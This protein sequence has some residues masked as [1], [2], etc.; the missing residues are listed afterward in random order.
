MPRPTE[1]LAHYVP[2]LSV[3]VSCRGASLTNS[4]GRRMTPCSFIIFEYD[5]FSGFV[6]ANEYFWRF[7]LLRFH[8]HAYTQKLR[9][10]YIFMVFAVHKTCRLLFP[11]RRRVARSFLLLKQ[12]GQLKIPPNGAPQMT[13]NK[14]SL[15]LNSQ[16]F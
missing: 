1:I 15:R 10:P 13:S 11:R 8:V 7:L 5:W 6:S 16:L 3:T 9:L 4:F 14:G 2:I 12:P